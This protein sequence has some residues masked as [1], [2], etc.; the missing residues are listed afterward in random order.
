M[1]TSNIRAARPGLAVLLAMAAALLSVPCAHAA[2]LRDICDV[3]GAQMNILKG[4]G[5]VVG[6]AGTGDKAEAAI[7]AQGRL[8]Q[9]M[10]IEISDPDLLASNNAAIVMVTAELPPFTKQ[11]TRIDVKVDSMHDAKSLEGGT[12]LETHL[13]GPGSS[14]TVYALA[15]GTV[16]VGGFNADGGG[17]TS[18]RRNHVAAGRI[19]MGATVERE[20]PSTITDGSRIV[21]TLKSPDF[22]TANKVQQAIGQAFGPGAAE[23]LT[24][25]TIR[26]TIPQARQDNLVAFIAEVMDVSVT[27]DPPA[28]VVINERTGTIV[29]GGNVIVRPCQVAHGSLTIRV[30]STPVIAQP[31]PFTDAQAIESRV[32]DLEVEM[33][34]AH[35]MPV[36]GTSAGDVAAALNKL[37]VTPRDMISIFQ[38]LRQAG[39]LEADLETM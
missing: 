9:R 13:R 27:T 23:A 31:L 30:A 32:V 33:M 20:V 19:P 3:Q 21:L 8:L 11:G 25:G 12:L 29:V 26:V 36:E 28:R 4:V 37:K 1:L 16:S 5:I 39:A 15:Q 14:E 22:I 6:L 35:L 34:E 38:A 17:G 2:R 18:V 10:G 24:A 7:L